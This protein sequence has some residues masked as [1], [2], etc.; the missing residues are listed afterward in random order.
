MALLVTF[1]Q[2]KEIGTYQIIQLKAWD[3]F[4][5]KMFLNNKSLIPKFNKEYLQR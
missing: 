5:L 4:D 2:Y 1:F 3:L